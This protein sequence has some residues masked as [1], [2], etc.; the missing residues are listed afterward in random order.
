[1]GGKVKDESGHRMTFLAGLAM[2]GVLGTLVIT[3]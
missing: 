2:G 3:R 1:M